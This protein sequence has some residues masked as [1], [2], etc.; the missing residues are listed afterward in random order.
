MTRDLTCLAENMVFPAD[1]ERTGINMNELIVGATGCGKSM[2]I[3]YPRLANTFDSSIVVPITKRAIMDKFAKSF[4]KKGYRVEVIDFAE[5]ENSTIGY[6]PLDYIKID[7]DVI[8]V[9]KSMVEAEY[10]KK[11]NHDPFW[12]LSAES[13]LGAIILLLRANEKYG[14]VRASFADFISFFRN[15][16]LDNSKR[17]KTRTNIDYLFEKLDRLEPGN[18][19]SMLWNSLISQPDRTANCIYGCT[20]TAI[21]KFT[22]E[23][24]KKLVSRENRISL[25]KLGEEKTV[26]FIRTSPVNRAL[27]TFVNMM[28]SDMFRDMFESAERNPKGR[29]DIPVHVICDDFACGTRIMNF[30]DYIS[31]F[32]AAGI[33]VSLLVQSESQLNEIYGQFGGTTIINNCDTYIYMGGMDYETCHSISQKANKPMEEIIGMAKEHI[34]V[35]RRGNDPVFVRRYQTLEDPEYIKVMED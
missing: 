5:P 6:D 33:S 14:G 1:S 13:T 22:S 20:N 18:Q 31:I 28:Y 32:R 16:K 34:I 19:A 12:N 15:L 11:S 2:S 3:A 35:F 4:K 10:E 8:N 26:L 25:R 27:N 7:E 23:N 17:E 30:E 21:D 29:L 9:T 24:V